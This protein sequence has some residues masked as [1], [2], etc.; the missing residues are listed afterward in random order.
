V[1]SAIT[2][3]AVIAVVVAVV[4]VVTVALSL[5]CHSANNDSSKHVALLQPPLPLLLPLT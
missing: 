2:V 4:A 1:L 5:R 3:H